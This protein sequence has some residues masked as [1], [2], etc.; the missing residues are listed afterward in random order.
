MAFV[1]L[2]VAAV[3]G[4]AEDPLRFFRPERRA[5][6]RELESALVA[7]IE[8][9]RL[10]QFHELCA[11]EPHVAGT[12]AD[13][14]L[15]VALAQTYRDWGLEVETHEVWLYLPRPVRAELEVISP[16]RRRL[17]LKEDV[18]A[19]DPWSGHR[20]IGMGW[21]AWS[22]SGEATGHVVYANYGTQG[23]LRPAEARSEWPSRTR[24]SSPATAATS[25]AT[26]RAS[27][28]RR[29]RQGS[30]SSPTLR[31]A[32]TWTASMYPEGGWAHPSA[33]QRGSL[34]TLPYQGDALTPVAPATKDA[35]RLD[36]ATVALPKIPV[37]PIG[38][39]A[40]Q[41]I[42]SRMTG[43]PVPA[44]W[45]G[46]LP[47][48]YRLTGGDALR[49]RLRVEQERRIV[50]DRE[51]RGDAPGGALPGAEGH[52]R[53]PSRCLDVRGGRPRRRHDRRARSGP[54]LR[55]GGD[56]A[57]R[58]PTA[59]SCSRTGAPRSS[60]SWAR[61]SGWRRGARSSCERPWPT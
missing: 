31:M 22:G 16:V 11:G 23:R 61:P 39:R 58:R 24:S 19:E 43:K 35:E 34:L 12:P 54:G 45:Q 32:A 48:A 9:K 27:P 13:R 44:G 4:F 42:L 15:I 47:F 37:Q 5:A 21:N 28:R 33:I 46:G 25:A 14:R 2:L 10:R 30:S 29:A 36:P 60:A 51:C 57:A 7:G 40:A 8:A 55:R 1:A 20:D 6:E 18:L 41:E 17:A 3:P 56:G 50:H 26:R 52:R 49:V 38:F 59:R 53:Q